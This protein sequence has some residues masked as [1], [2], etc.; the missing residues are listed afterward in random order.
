VPDSRFGGAVRGLT[1]PSLTRALKST[2]EAAAAK[3]LAGA[4]ALP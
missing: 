4:V 2:D 3:P 1:V